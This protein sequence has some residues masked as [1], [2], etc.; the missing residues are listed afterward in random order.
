MV[1]YCSDNNQPALISKPPEAVTIQPQQPFE[2]VTTVS[3]ANAGN[4]VESV[5]KPDDQPKI[6]GFNEPL[7]EPVMSIM[8][9]SNSE[10]EEE[11]E[12]EEEEEEE[13]EVARSINVGPS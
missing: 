1:L 12:D 7:P 4:R 8:F 9:V 11:D 13:E 6:L 3:P 10:D 2:P 5:A